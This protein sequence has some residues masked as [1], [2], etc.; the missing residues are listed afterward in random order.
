MFGYSH[1]GRPGNR[2][3]GIVVG[4]DNEFYLEL[5]KAGILGKQGGRET[6]NLSWFPE[7][8]IHS[9]RCRT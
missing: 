4:D 3:Q 9:G 1:T 2:Q 7:F 6:L 8:L 5:R